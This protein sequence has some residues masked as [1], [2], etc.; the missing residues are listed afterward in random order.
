[1][2]TYRVRVTHDKLMSDGTYDTQ[3]EAASTP[4]TDEV[5]KG[6]AVHIA[7]G[8]G[9][10]LVGIQGTYAVLIK[11]P[12]LVEGSLTVGLIGGGS[13]VFSFKNE[14]QLTVSAGSLFVNVGTTCDINY[15]ILK[16]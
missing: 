10:S 12:A 6:D 5:I 3:A 1:M 14:L 2:A 4:A 7:A 8:V 16:L 13:Q 15:S 9:K 11:L